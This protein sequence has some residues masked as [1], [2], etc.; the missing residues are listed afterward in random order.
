MNA[1]NKPAQIQTR[2]AAMRAAMQV[3]GIAAYLVPSSDPHIS[4]YLPDRWKTREWLSG[5]TGSMGTLVIMLE[6]VAIFAD[7]RYWIQAERELIGTGIQLQKVPTGAPVHH[8]EWIAARINANDVVA[9]EGSLLG[10]AGARAVEQAVLAKGGKTRT[11]IDLVEQVWVNRPALPSALV[12]EHVA[13]QAAVLR[14]D[15][16]AQVRAAMQRHGAQYHFISTLDDIAW[17][18]NLRGQDVE[19][20]PVFLAHVLI[21]ASTVTVFVDQTKISSQLRAVLQQDGVALA[22]YDQAL[23]ALQQIASGHSVLIDPRRITLGFIQAFGTNVK[24]IEQMN[25]STLLKSRK[26]AVEAQHVRE[27]ME[28]DGAAL[29]EFFAWFESALNKERITEVTVDEKITAARKKRP[30]FVCPSFATIAGFNANGALNHYRA[31]PNAHSVIEG[32]GLLLIDSGGQYKGGTTDITRVLAINQVSAAMKRDCTLVLRGMINLTLARFPRGT[33]S[34]MLDALARTPIWQAGIE[35]GHGTGHG[36]GYFLNVHEGPQSISKVVPEATMA[37]E[38]GMITSNEPG[39]YREG[40]WGV[41]IENL[42]MNIAFDQGE[43]DKQFGDFL[44]FETL[45]LCPIDT[46]CIDKSMMRPHEIDWLNTYHA[47]VRARLLPHLNGADYKQA[48]A[49]LIKRTAVF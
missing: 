34:P 47:N 9:F 21:D 44:Q 26:T 2:I 33:L 30:G 25:P 42:V 39:I 31:T 15:K 37:M 13:P 46:R 17:L 36:V 49:W 29:C 28:Q 16:I 12:Y 32:D 40:Q 11:D 20:N 22:D 27:A 23:P 18:L 10:V 24:V 38:L 41:R 14:A 5:F 4:E 8:I 3:H 43:T 48:K 35:Y 6:E 1:D 45:T 19:F 7:S